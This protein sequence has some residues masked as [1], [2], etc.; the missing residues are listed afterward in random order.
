V[1]KA[2]TTKIV[3][4][5]KA[6]AGDAIPLSAVKRDNIGH[7][8]STIYSKEKLFTTATGGAIISRR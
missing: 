6:A 7:S 2:S 5:L 4:L 1:K 8:N 3:V